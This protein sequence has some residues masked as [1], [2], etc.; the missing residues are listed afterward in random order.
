MV[1]PMS[2]LHKRLMLQ[3][4]AAALQSVGGNVK[5][6]PNAV[7][8]YTDKDGYPNVTITQTYGAT[9]DGY[10]TPTG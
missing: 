5:K 9:A 2:L 4:L 1:T 6:S 10:G 8:I 7:N 3:L